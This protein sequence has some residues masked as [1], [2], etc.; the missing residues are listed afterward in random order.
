MKEA[1]R[2]YLQGACR[3]TS[4][5]EKVHVCGSDA[6]RHNLGHRFKRFLAQSVLFGGVMRTKLLS[7]IQVICLNFFFLIP[8]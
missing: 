1:W 7:E 5:A 8:T 4:V 3:F 2:I 6:D